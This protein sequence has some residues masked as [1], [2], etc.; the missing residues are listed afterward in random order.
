MTALNQWDSALYGL[1]RALEAL[2]A[3]YYAS[4]A[5][6]GGEVLPAAAEADLCAAQAKLKQQQQ[7]SNAEGVRRRRVLVGQVQGQPGATSQRPSMWS[8][9]VAVLVA[10]LQRARRALV[11]ADTQP[12]SDSDSAEAPGVVTAVVSMTTT[13]TTTT[14]TSATATHSSTRKG[15]GQDGPVFGREG[16]LT[17]HI[18][19]KPGTG[20]DG[21]QPDPLQ[22]DPALL[23]F[24]LQ[25][26]VEEGS[27]FALSPRAHRAA[28]GATQK[29]DP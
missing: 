23:M 12:A 6:V 9:V 4:A 24:G 13:T 29:P 25:G 15:D 18:K 5:V 20:Q 19:L 27:I 22:V 21:G 11:A 7:A 10:P 1:G 28:C 14:T 2:D 17:Y 8:R 26:S 3:S 16:F